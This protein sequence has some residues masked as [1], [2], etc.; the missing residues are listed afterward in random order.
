[1]AI[2]LLVLLI[3]SLPL[4]FVSIISIGFQFTKERYY[5]DTKKS[6]PYNQGQPKK[7][8]SLLKHPFFVG[9]CILL[10]TSIFSIFLIR[11]PEV[12]LK[13]V[14]DFKQI[15]NPIVIEFNGIFAALGIFLNVFY[16]FKSKDVYEYMKK[17]FIDLDSWLNLGE[18][19]SKYAYVM[20]SRFVKSPE[21]IDALTVQMIQENSN[22]KEMKDKI[23]SDKFPKRFDSYVARKLWG[24]FS[25]NVKNLMKIDF[26]HRIMEAQYFKSRKKTPESIFK[27]LKLICSQKVSQNDLYP[28][29]LM[30]RIQYLWMVRNLSLIDE[31]MSNYLSI[32]TYMYSWIT[33]FLLW[34]IYLKLAS[35]SKSV[36]EFFMRSSLASTV[37]LATYFSIGNTVLMQ[38]VFQGTGT[39]EIPYPIRD[40]SIG[41][42]IWREITNLLLIGFLSSFATGSI[43]I[44]MLFLNR[45]SSTAQFFSL[46]VV[47]CLVFFSVVSATFAY[48]SLL[49][50]HDAIIA[51]KNTKLDK[52]EQ[53]IR[54]LPASNERRVKA[55]EHYNDVRELPDWSL[56][57]AW[58]LTVVFGFL[59]PTLAQ[60]FLPKVLFGG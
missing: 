10:A 11:F 16:I 36:L 48:S 41:I 17:E 2:T 55:L 13:I 18:K 33:V 53:I 44:S 5:S 30:N 15:K 25:P 23:L 27:E 51:S 54:G 19:K 26:L 4:A 34:S 39:F 28:D 46:E 20:Q 47:S 35:D 9:S 22:W 59:L 52:L 50:L 56:S 29:L 38:I 60:V 58:I 7:R 45:Q 6:L 14:E 31:A 8:R 12:R 37:L 21:V 42:P 32:K 49:V 40:K 3:I 1:M 57:E 43:G 24:A